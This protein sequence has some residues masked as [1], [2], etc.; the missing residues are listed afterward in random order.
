ME[1]WI[2][3]ANQV[4]RP[5]FLQQHP[6]KYLNRLIHK[7]KERIKVILQGGHPEEEQ[8][9]DPAEEVSVKHISCY[10]GYTPKYPVGQ[11]GYDTAILQGIID[12][13]KAK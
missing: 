9:Q 5:D 2:G 7:S 10:E 4:L 3:L 12:R 13:N 8:N 6:N 1:K 11:K